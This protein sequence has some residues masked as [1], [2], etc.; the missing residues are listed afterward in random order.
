[1]SMKAAGAALLCELWAAERARIRLGRQETSRT[2]QSQGTAVARRHRMATEPEH[3]P[4]VRTLVTMH[5]NTGKAHVAY[6]IFGLMALWLPG[7]QSFH[8]QTVAQRTRSRLRHQPRR[9][10]PRLPR[11][12]MPRPRGD[13]GGS[14]GDEDGRRRVNGSGKVCLALGTVVVFNLRWV[15]ASGFC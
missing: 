5:K 12:R 14:G 3:Q 4:W 15:L 7:L 2:L 1:M 10:H 13:P 8:F 9:S 11:R 6:G